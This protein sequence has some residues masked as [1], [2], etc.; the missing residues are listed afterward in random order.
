MIY[1]ISIA[2][3]GAVGGIVLILAM[4]NSGFFNGWMRRKLFG[5]NKDGWVL[6]QRGN[7]YELVPVD[8]DNQMTKVEIDGDIQFLE[9]DDRMLNLDGIPFG[10]A[11][12]GPREIVDVE[13]AAAAAEV[14]DKTD[15]G[16]SNIDQDTFTLE[17]VQD[18]IKVGTLS[19]E[20]GKITYLNPFV[21]VDTSRIVDLRNI[22]KLFA[23]SG[24]SDTPRKAA[25]NAIE[26]ERSIQGGDWG[27]IVQYGMIIAA[28]F[29]GGIMVEYIAGS[30]GG[31]GGS[32]NLGMMIV[33]PWI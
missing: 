5:S 13:T 17:D 19:T 15:V 2:S 30:G 1:E 33:Y 28:F 7:R 23:H 9:G 14:A 3:A 24:T 18:R 22:V 20:D 16:G 27:Q 12:E 31:G 25:K 11:L 32:I 10:L 26:A 8:R 29:L 6:L 4:M 21:D